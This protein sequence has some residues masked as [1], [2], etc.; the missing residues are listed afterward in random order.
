MG[1]NLQAIYGGVAAPQ[2]ESAIARSPA[3]AAITEKDAGM[4]AAMTFV[5]MI[6]LLVMLRVVYEVA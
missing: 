3:T 4:G 5:F 1:L 6:G 2:T